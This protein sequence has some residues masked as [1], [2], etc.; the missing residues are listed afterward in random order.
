M[1]RNNYLY[2]CPQGKSA[3]QNHVVY[4]ASKFFL[5]GF[6]QGLRREGLR[7]GIK[8][9]SH[10]PK[11]ITDNICCRLQLLDQELSRQIWMPSERKLLLW[12]KLILSLRWF[13]KRLVVTVIYCNTRSTEQLF[14][15]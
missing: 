12:K 9:D 6:S 10:K 15:R 4:S 1:Y 11:Y 8:E 14:R 3:T 2:A 7:D 5:E 13:S